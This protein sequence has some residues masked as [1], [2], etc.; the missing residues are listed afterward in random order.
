V[1]S[2]LVVVPHPEHCPRS[3]GFLGNYGVRRMR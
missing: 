1:A 3:A 2:T